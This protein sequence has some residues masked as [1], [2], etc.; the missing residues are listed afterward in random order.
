MLLLTKKKHF[1]V[2]FEQ[3][4]LLKHEKFSLAV[5]IYSLCNLQVDSCMCRHTQIRVTQELNKCRSNYEKMSRKDNLSLP[6]ICI[7]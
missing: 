2:L 1:K 3:F 6:A 7:L 5:S 4:S